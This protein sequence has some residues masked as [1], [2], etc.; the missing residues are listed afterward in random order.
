MNKQEAIKELQYLKIKLYVDYDDPEP[1]EEALNM[2]IEA[3]QF[4]DIMINNPKTAK[5]TP[6]VCKNCMEGGTE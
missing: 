1:Y 5:P 4:Q 3:L 2:A 6:E